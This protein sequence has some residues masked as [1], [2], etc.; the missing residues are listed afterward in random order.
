MLQ[1]YADFDYSK[2]AI[3][4]II[5]E[6]EGVEKDSERARELRYLR[7]T[8]SEKLRQDGQVLADE[9]Y[10]PTRLIDVNIRREQPQFVAYLTQSRR[11]VVFN[12]L[13]GLNNP[14]LD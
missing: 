5:A 12:S 10:I 4:S 14:A 3:N 6:W 13:D 2:T 9:S 8:K 1:S 11:S 7:Y